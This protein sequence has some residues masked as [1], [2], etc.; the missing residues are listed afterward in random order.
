M[1]EKEIL[2]WMCPDVAHSRDDDEKEGDDEKEKDAPNARR[3]S[4]QIKSHEGGWRVFRIVVF[5]TH[6]HSEVSWLPRIPMM[7]AGFCPWRCLGLCIILH[8]RCRF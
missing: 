4:F 5:T 3:I 2:V 8:C 1:L 7:S 6:I